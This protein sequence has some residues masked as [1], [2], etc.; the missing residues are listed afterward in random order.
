MTTDGTAD[1][2]RGLGINESLEKL[3]IADAGIDERLLPVLFNHIDGLMS[4]NSTLRFLDLRF[5]YISDVGAAEVRDQ[6]MKPNEE[7]IR[8]NSTL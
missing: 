4:Q 8:I 6:L 3:N 7:G 1:I 5:N 2:I